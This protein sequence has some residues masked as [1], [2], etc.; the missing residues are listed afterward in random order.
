M[1]LK[2]ELEK[3]TKTKLGCSGLVVAQLPLAAL[4]GD[5]GLAPSLTGLL[6]AICSCSSRASDMTPGH[7][8]HA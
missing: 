7:Q 4:A 8:A 2:A 5:L 1:I 3:N 6:I